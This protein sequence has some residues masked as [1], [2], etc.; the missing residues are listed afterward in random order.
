M[1]E[2]EVRSGAFL[3]CFQVS[4]GNMSACLRSLSPICRSP[5]TWKRST[6]CPPPLYARSRL[7]H[8]NLLRF[9]PPSLQQLQYL[10][11][12]R[13]LL[14]MLSHGK[15]QTLCGHINISK[16]S[17]L[18]DEKTERSRHQGAGGLSASPRTSLS[19]TCSSPTS[20]GNIKKDGYS[21][22]VQTD[23]DTQSEENEKAVIERSQRDE[24]NSSESSDRFQKERGEDLR[25]ATLPTKSLSRCIVI[26]RSKKRGFVAL[27]FLRP[28]ATKTPK[29]EDREESRNKGRK[30]TKSFKTEPTLEVAP[31]GVGSLVLVEALGG[32]ILE[33]DMMPTPFNRKKYGT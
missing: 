32:A 29:T 20:W 15:T 18:L 28:Q 23:Q 27:G 22:P 5:P 8:Q 21:Q 24:E 4:P 7:L 11:S 31:A 30:A 2:G 13:E 3:V 17:C 19:T 16:A 9:L 10:R 12:R 25:L 1:R 14:R 33:P 26:K 6:I